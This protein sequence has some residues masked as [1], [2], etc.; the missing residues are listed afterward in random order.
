[1][2][3]FRLGKWSDDE[4]AKFDKALADLGQ[5][6]WHAISARVGTRSH[7]QVY[8]FQRRRLEV[9]KKLADKAA[10][11]KDEASLQVVVQRYMSDHG[12]TQLDKVS[13]GITASTLPSSVMTW[14]SGTYG[15]DQAPSLAARLRAFLSSPDKSET[16]TPAQETG[17]K[18]ADEDSTG[19]AGEVAPGSK[20]H[21]AGQH[22]S[23]AA[24]PAG[25]AG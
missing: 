20:K 14:L 13:L 9:Q 19:D 22:E 17:E 8:D 16:E 25:K 3:E 18:G 24:A 7:M 2:Q 6:D 21:H 15:G 23:C 12:L 5:H 1:M 10:E 4:V 11:K